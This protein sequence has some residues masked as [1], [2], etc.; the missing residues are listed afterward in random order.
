MSKKRRLAAW[1]MTIVLCLGLFAPP[2][3]SAADLYFVSVNDS[4]LALTSDTM[5]FWSGGVLHVPYTVFDS[6]SNGGINLGISC[7]YNRNYNTVLLYNNEQILTFHLDTGLCLDELTG[8]TYPNRAVMRNGRPYLSLSTVCSFFDLEYTYNVLPNVSQGFLVRIKSDSAVLSDD[9][10]ID[11]ASDLIDRRLREY[12]QSLASSGS[13]SSGSGGT[14][15]PTQPST[16]EKPSSASVPTYLAF[17]CDS[18]DGLASILD[19][20]RAKS[21]YALFFV[22]PD[23]LEQEDNLIRRM[24]GSGHS[25]GIL[26]QGG[27]QEETA[28]L[29][30]EGARLLEELAYTRT[31]LAYVPKAHQAG[32]EGSGWIFWKE[33][34]NLTPSDTVGSRYFASSTLKRLSGRTRSTYL[35]MEGGSNAARVL[36]TLLD[37]LNEQH[38]VVS[39]PMETKL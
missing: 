24:L 15:T 8:V 3:A 23:L 11:A 22:T 39:I 18:A 38:F 5:P 1:L 12:N 9:K 34:L 2:T 37:Q 16:G 6:N 20:L 13:S 26:A 28:R 14:V 10:F 32:L 27:T 36:S 17:R 21:V 7:T 30:E 35:T 4:L 19:T 25:V 31:V 33:T 29:L